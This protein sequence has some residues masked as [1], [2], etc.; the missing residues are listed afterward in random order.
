LS[1][2]LWSNAEIALRPGDPIISP[3]KKI[4]TGKPVS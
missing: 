3:I 2:T 1:T 4:F